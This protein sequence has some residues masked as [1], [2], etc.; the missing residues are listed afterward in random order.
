MVEACTDE[1]LPSSSR[2]RHRVTA[3]LLGVVSGAVLYALPLGP[4]WRHYR[5]EDVQ[6]DWS[7]QTRAVK[8]ASSIAYHPHRGTILVASDEGYICELDRDLV[9]V[10]RYDVLTDLEGLAVHPQ[11]GTVFVAE[12]TFQAVYEYDLQRRRILRCMDVDLQAY[13]AFR[14]KLEDDNAGLEGIA[15]VPNALGELTL[16]AVVQAAPARLIALDADLSSGATEDAR[17]R[18]SAAGLFGVQQR[19]AVRTAWDL[20]VA[21]LSDVVYDPQLNQLWVVCS[22]DAVLLLVDRGGK[23]QRRLRL[24]GRQPEGLAFLPDGRTLVAD[25]KGGLWVSQRY[26]ERLMAR[27]AGN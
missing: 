12:E 27:L 26:R 17:Q 8:E 23:I 20:G 4:W 13:P 3:L 9:V 6:A 10:G 7:L 5:A 25:D 15:I 2:R 19:I 18:C 22:K 11:T 16:M 24:P 1:T 21:Q 14:R